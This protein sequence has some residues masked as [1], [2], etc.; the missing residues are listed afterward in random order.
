LIATL[1]TDAFTEFVY[2]PTTSRYR[3]RDGVGR[4]RFISKQAFLSQVELH[5]SNRQRELVG[6]ADRLISRVINLE[7]FQR[8]ASNILNDLHVS[9]LILGRGGAEKID[10]QDIERVGT[11]VKRQLYAGNDNGRSFGI[12]HLAREIKQGLVSPAQLRSRL[13][14]YAE[15]GKVSYWEAWKR[16]ESEQ[17]QIYGVRVLGNT[18]HCQDCLAFAAEKPKPIEQVITPGTYCQCMSNCGCRIESLTLLQA[19]ERGMKDP[20]SKEKRRKE[21]EKI[22][23]MVFRKR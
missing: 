14:M 9:N 6:L 11:E 1:R 19:V 23:K 16:T 13:E 5:I 22:E 15:S 2:D 10:R 21:L 8:T 4:G 3:I 18:Q 7:Q 12:Q 20:R 17:G